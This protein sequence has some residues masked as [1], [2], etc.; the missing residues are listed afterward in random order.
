MRILICEDERDIADILS[1]FLIGEGYEVV[2]AADGN[3]AIR[4]F[5]ALRPDLVLVDVMLPGKDGW[6]VLR[7]IRARSTCPVI[8]LTALGGVENEVRGLS[9]GA[10]DYI[11]K[12]SFNLDRVKAR[13]EAVLRRAAAPA[14][15]LELVIDDARKEVRLDGRPISLSPKEYALLTLLAS[16]SGRVFSSEE[17]RGRLW[18][19]NSYASPEDVQKYVYLLRKKFQDDPENPR[20][21]LTVRGFGYRLV[22]TLALTRPARPGREVP[23]EGEPRSA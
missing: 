4:Q 2:V 17:I 5:V 15:A 8:V 11:S 18:S 3:D 9:G 12:A 1:Q 10:D 16:E 23:Q 20:I 22:E 19:A 21:V 7:E 6:E 14:P 13:I